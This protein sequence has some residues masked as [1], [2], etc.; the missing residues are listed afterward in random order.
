MYYS[1]IYSIATAVPKAVDT[2]NQT[3]SASPDF[4]QIWNIASTFGLGVAVLIMWLYSLL[5]DIKDYKERS[6]EHSK[7]LLELSKE[8]ISTMKSLTQ[9]VEAIAPAISASSLDNRKEIELAIRDLKEHIN[10]QCLA[11]ERIVKDL[12]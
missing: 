3:Q 8:N 10:N 12:K 11:I 2:L 6:K 9:V 7:E 1:L 4:S 5:K